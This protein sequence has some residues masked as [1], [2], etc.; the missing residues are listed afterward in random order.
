MSVDFSTRIHR[1]GFIFIILALLASAWPIRYLTRGWRLA[2]VCACILPV[3]GRRD[4]KHF[5]NWQPASVYHDSFQESRLEEHPCRLPQWNI[6][7]HCYPLHSLEIPLEKTFKFV[8][9]MAPCRS[10]TRSKTL[11]KP[12]ASYSSPDS[13]GS[14]CIAGYRDR[15]TSLLAINRAMATLK[16]E[17]VAR[18]C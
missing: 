17:T 12:R 11:P 16:E 4:R 2:C 13:D 8:I 10:K 9:F 6:L 3:L 15:L 18:C 14:K 1:E 5:G 7:Q